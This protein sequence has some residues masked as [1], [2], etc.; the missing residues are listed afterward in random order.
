M[1]ETPETLH[2]KFSELRYEG[3]YEP[4]AIHSA[5]I[6]DCIKHSGYRDNSKWEDSVNDH[7]GE[8]A[9]ALELDDRFAQRIPLRPHI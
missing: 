8:A 3:R 9:L 2:L 4:H 5:L 1:G 7:R 6:P